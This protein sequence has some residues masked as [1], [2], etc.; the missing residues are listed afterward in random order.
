MYK[1]SHVITLK[2]SY[3]FFVPI[4]GDVMK[5]N[6]EIIKLIA[7]SLDYIEENLLEDIHLSDIAENYNISVSLYC[8]LFK[9]LLGFTVKEYIIK[10]RMALSARDLIFTKESILFIALK[11]GYS[12]YEQFSR[13]FKKVFKVSPG[14]YRREGVYVNIFPKIV[15]KVS[16]LDGGDYMTEMG[17]QNVIKKLKKLVEGYILV[18]D[19]DRF[20]EVNKNF[21]RKAGDFVLVE[22]AKRIKKTLDSF[23]NDV[24]VIRMGADEFVVILK[25][26][27]EEFVKKLS[28]KILEETNASIEFE[29]KLINVSVSIG[30]SKFSANREEE[31]EI[32]EK[33]RNAML[34][35]KK[36]GR[37]KF[38]IK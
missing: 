17:N 37:S 38:K 1:K 13:A 23:L 16:D 15:L 35:A 19:I 31:E 20:A 32:I 6:V 25:G 36:E 5:M 22:I 29:E 34:A 33:A 21:G 27:D 10:R 9:N 2:I 8:K 26:K 30:I 28:Q 24:D 18:I 12:G 11:Y 3:N 14:R 7:D 4:K